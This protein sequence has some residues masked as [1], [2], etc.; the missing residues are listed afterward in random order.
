MDPYNK[1]KND[2]DSR[3]KT[4]TRID[5]LKLMKKLDEIHD[6]LATRLAAIETY[7]NENNVTAVRGNIKIYRRLLSESLNQLRD[8]IQCKQMEILNDETYELQKSKKEV[9]Y[10]RDVL[11]SKTGIVRELLNHMETEDYEQSFKIYEDELMAEAGELNEE[12][13][14]LNDSAVLNDKLFKVKNIDNN[15]FINENIDEENIVSVDE[16]YRFKFN[17]KFEE[18]D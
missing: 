9:K 5:I 3:S 8:D 14:E 2:F 11:N 18:V 4:G 15:V 17:A 13:P 1:D 12:I 7:A 6:Y 10:L 16:N